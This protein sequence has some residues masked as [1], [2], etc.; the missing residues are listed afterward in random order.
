MTMD[1]DLT[2]DTLYSSI[3]MDY[4]FP[5]EVVWFIEGPLKD[6]KRKFPEE[7]TTYTYEDK[8]LPKESTFMIVDGEEIE[9]L[10]NKIL[11]KL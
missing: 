10:D 1:T 5:P 11:Y 6:T 2:L 8:T 3:K 4:S 9:V 7:V